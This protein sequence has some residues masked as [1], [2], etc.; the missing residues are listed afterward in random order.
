MK[1]TSS[2]RGGSAAG[3]VPLLW[4][5][6]PAGPPSRLGLPEPGSAASVPEMADEQMASG[7]TLAT[8]PE[9]LQPD[10]PAVLCGESRVAVVSEYVVGQDLG[11]VDE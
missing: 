7:S 10:L 5:R 1:G 11:E 9:S 6:G 3:C 2:P 4:E 8:A